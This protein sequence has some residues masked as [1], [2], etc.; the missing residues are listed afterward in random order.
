MQSTEDIWFQGK[1]GRI[2]VRQVGEIFQACIFTAQEAGS[3]GS[4]VLG[5]WSNPDKARDAGET[6]LAMR[7]MGKTDTQE[8]D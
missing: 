7:E 3:A 2:R 5:D 1:V 8:P 4:T 6:V